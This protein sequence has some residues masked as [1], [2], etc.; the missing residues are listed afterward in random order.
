MKSKYFYVLVFLLL[1][2]LA[3]FNIKNIGRLAYPI[4]Y[5]EEITKYS[6]KYK[7]D[8]YYVAAVIKTE[9]NYNS[10]AVSS[11]GAYGLMQITSATAQWAASEMKITGF[12][13]EKLKEPDFNISMGCWYLNN[14]KTEFDGNMDLAT[15]AYNGGIGNVKKW[16]QQYENSKDG[17]SLYYIPFK[18][19]DQ[20]V[21]KV[22]VNYEI[23]KF[24]YV[25]K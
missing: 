16:L 4:K 20:Y 9:S 13:V 14:L 25:K 10:D 22:K 3:A 21:K 19:T 7:L 18:E 17:K 24:L 6:D 23:Y 8:P 5:K 1:C 12:T 11:K 2:I 15:A